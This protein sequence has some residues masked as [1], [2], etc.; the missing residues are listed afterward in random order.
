M[1]YLGD[2]PF[3]PQDPN[4]V[5]MYVC[6]PTVYAA[7][8]LGN[9][10]SAVNFD[11]LHRVLRRLYPEVVFVRNYTDID[12]KIMD[13]ARKLGGDMESS[14]RSVVEV[15]TNIYEAESRK[16]HIL[17]PTEKPTVSESMDQIRRFI[18]RL[19]ENGSAYESAGHV[20]FD[21]Q[22]N[23]EF[24]LND[25]LDPALLREGGD[26]DYKRHPHDFVL[27]KPSTGDQPGWDSPWS[28][29]RPGWHIEC[30]AMILDRLGETID[31]HGGGIDLRFPHHENEC[32]QSHALTGKPLARYWVHNGMLDMRG[33]MSK[34]TGNVVNL[35]AALEQV[36]AE[37]VR[38]FLLTAHYRQPLKFTWGALDAA[39]TS[40]VSLQRAMRKVGDR[41]EE[42]YLG[43]LL[44][45]L[46]T[47][48]ALSEMHALAAKIV[49][50]T[51]TN[52]EVSRFVS[53][54]DVL[55]LRENYQIFYDSVVMSLITQ[56]DQAR[57][58]K[59]FQLADRL[60]AE[61]VSLGHEVNDAPLERSP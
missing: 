30:S 1:L 11:V 28:F 34:S 54:A 60:R 23:P 36:S 56:R 20:L 25:N 33:K 16:L 8:H 35:N 4:R 42:N 12:D 39:E 9:L 61:L 10:R 52:E 3:V 59:N 24:F 58:E 45:D 14:M 48:R 7:P 49:N 18:Y 37:T 38:Y 5:T 44:Q 15:A 32:A 17:E 29:G 22:K 46:N 47:P 6:G 50:D 51:A 40:L 31:I 13:E 19:I 2:R 57:R 21:R 26:A 43:P 27:W 55:G 53:L 41:H